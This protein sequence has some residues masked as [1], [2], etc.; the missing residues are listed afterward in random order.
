MNTKEKV[1]TTFKGQIVKAHF[2]TKDGG[3]D[4]WGVLKREARDPDNIVTAYDFRKKAYR[5]FNL[6]NHFAIANARKCASSL[7]HGVIANA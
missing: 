6:D 4:F 7:I 1:L 2:I 5:R 3:R